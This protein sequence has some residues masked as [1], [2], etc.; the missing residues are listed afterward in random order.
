MKRKVWRIPY[1]PHSTNRLLGLET[2]TYF[3]SRTDH[4]NIEHIALRNIDFTSY[5]SG[6][7]AAW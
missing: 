4:S 6:M 1:L 3:K 7:K 5:I 2:L